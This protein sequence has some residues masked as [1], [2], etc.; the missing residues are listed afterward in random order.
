MTCKKH[1]WVAT[2]GNGR[3]HSFYAKTSYD[4]R[5]WVINH[6]DLSLDWT[7]TEIWSEGGEC[8]TDLREE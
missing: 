7:T 5:Q 6:V 3:A 8:V 1:N 4:A 2:D